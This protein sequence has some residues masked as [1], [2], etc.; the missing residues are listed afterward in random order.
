VLPVYFLEASRVG[1]RAAFQWNSSATGTGSF[2]VM[3]G[4]DL[5]GNGAPR[6]RSNTAPESEQNFCRH[7]EELLPFRSTPAIPKRQC[8]KKMLNSSFSHGNGN[9]PFR[10]I[11]PP[12]TEIRGV[13]G[14]QERS[15][16]HR[17]ASSKPAAA[18]KP[19]CPDPS[20]MFPPSSSQHAKKE[21][22]PEQRPSIHERVFSKA[23][24]WRTAQIS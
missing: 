18:C 4:R 3:S 21:K 11:P 17:P 14:E 1:Q 12:L 24:A 13:G 5:E 8:R 23:S 19:C 16:S 15:S 6:D 7:H 9:L 10:T 20:S 22:T 2:E